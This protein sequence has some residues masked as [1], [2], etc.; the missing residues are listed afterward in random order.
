MHP[1]VVPQR[2]QTPI[3]VSGVRLKAGAIFTLVENTGGG[4]SCKADGAGGFPLAVSAPTAGDTLQVLQVGATQ[5]TRGDFPYKVCVQ[6]HAGALFLELGTDSLLAAN[7]SGM[8]P[9]KI[10][11]LTAVTLTLEGQNMDTSDT[12]RLLPYSGSESCPVDAPAS[13]AAI[14]L[15]SQGLW[16]FALSWP[17]LPSCRR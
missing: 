14:S 9:G 7:V 17:L 3:T 5:L 1:S 2:T 13:A 8:S 16:I 4:Q 11:Q 6:F 10:P 12:V 15:T